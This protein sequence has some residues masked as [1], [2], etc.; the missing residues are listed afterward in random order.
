MN[1]KTFKNGQD[2]L[3]VPMRLLITASNELPDAD[4]GLDALYDRMLVRVFVNRI[5]E[6][7]NFKAML[8]G[9]V[10]CCKSWIQNLQ[11]PMKNIPH[12]KSKLMMLC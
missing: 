7:Q 5:Q 12:G 8:M 3:P 2:V 1:E 6:K 9:M 10:L 4:S 11:L